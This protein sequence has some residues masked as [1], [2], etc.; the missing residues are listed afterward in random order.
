[1]TAV[2]Q[3]N[4]S[5]WHRLMLANVSEDGGNSRRLGSWYATSP[6]QARK[7]VAH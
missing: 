4:W 3:N 6:E 1:M 2:Y 7:G 5:N